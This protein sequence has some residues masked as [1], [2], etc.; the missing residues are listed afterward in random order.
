MEE[1]SIFY[2]GVRLLNGQLGLWSNSTFPRKTLLSQLWDQGALLNPVIGIRLDLVRPRITIGALDP[3]DYVGEINWVEVRGARARARPGQAEGDE[4]ASEGWRE[5]AFVIDGLKGYNGSFIPF[6]TQEISATLSSFFRNVV[7][8]PEVYGQYYSNP[9]YISPDLT[10]ENGDRIICPNAT[11]NDQLPPAPFTVTINGVDYPLVEAGN[12][13]RKTWKLDRCGIGLV[14]YTTAMN[15]GSTRTRPVTDVELG[16]PFMRS[17]Y[18][19]YRFPTSDSPDCL[20]HIGFAFPSNMNHTAEQ[21]NQQPRTLPP[22]R[23]RCLSLSPPIGEPLSNIS[24]SQTGRASGAYRV[25]G[26][27]SRGRQVQLVGANELRR[28]T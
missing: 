13:I 23:D 15:T 9:D 1:L 6:D 22:L 12:W 26:D 5:D 21:I 20:P 11:T 3:E 18:I 2:P 17:V 27:A 14:N 19:A 24:Q 25:Y 8:P 16:L 4:S 7:V 10:V 28:R